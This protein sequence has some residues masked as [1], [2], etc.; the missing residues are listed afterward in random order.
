M[1]EAD[2]DEL[3]FGFSSEGGD[4]PRNGSK[5]PPGKAGGKSSGKG[6]KGFSPDEPFKYGMLEGL[7]RRD[8]EEL[9][10]RKTD[11]K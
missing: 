1:L 11:E 8:V 6:H 2:G 3:D 7:S 5:L 10:E 4:T 9:R